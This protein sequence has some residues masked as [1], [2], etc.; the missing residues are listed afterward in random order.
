M[1][2]FLGIPR[3]LCTWNIWTDYP[4]EIIKTESQ[5]LDIWFKAAPDTPDGAGFKLLI[6]DYYDGCKYIIVLQNLR[7]KKT[8]FLHM[9]KKSLISA[10]RKPRIMLP[11]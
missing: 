11:L 7:H 10:S 4:T 3:P 2:I 5:N 6:V 1:I 9:H 8:C